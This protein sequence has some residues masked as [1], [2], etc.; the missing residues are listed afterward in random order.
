MKIIYIP[1]NK[2]FQILEE[3]LLKTGAVKEGKK[4]YVFEDKDGDIFSILF[5]KFI[6][7]DL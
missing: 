1:F 6:D 5:S 2:D 7:S 3:Y 4:N